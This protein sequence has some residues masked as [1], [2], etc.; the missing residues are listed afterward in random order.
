MRWQ[1]RKHPYRDLIL[2]SS[3]APL[4]FL[5]FLL[6][7]IF[8]TSAEL[9]FS[10][11]KVASYSP[12]E[13]YG[14]DPLSGLFRLSAIFVLSFNVLL[15]FR[16]Y[17]RLAATSF[18]APLIMFLILVLTFFHRLQTL[19]LT[20]PNYLTDFFPGQSLFEITLRSIPVVDYLVLGW[21]GTIFT[22]NLIRIVNRRHSISLK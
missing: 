19:V 4:G 17:L 11:S 1:F 12:N 7:G 14:M 6:L 3:L 13:D 8:A 5:G 21:L 20:D 18:A 16:Q 10:V 2:A 22:W 9:L 15:Y